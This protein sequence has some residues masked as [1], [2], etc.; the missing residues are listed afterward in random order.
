MSSKDTLLGWGASKSDLNPAVIAWLSEVCMSAERS[1]M[2]L[3]ASFWSVVG[4]CKGSGL[5]LGTFYPN[6]N[7]GKFS[8]MGLSTPSFF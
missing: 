2:L 7:L 5:S 6:S 1:S 8:L 3:G 4:C